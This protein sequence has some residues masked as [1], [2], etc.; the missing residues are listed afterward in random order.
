MFLFVVRHLRWMA[1]VPLFPQIFDGFLLASVWLIDPERIKA[2]EMLEEAMRSQPDVSVRIHRLGGMEFYHRDS[3]ELGH[4]HGHG[5]LD[6]R[7]KKE[8][9]TM[10]L[11]AG[12]AQPH[13]VLP[14]TGWVSLPIKS[15]ADVPLA[16]KLLEAARR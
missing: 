7:L 3:K 13:H 9:A 16:L 14:H 12:R 8:D 4:L 10:W 15:R 11:A 5:L 6:A 2:M 1:R